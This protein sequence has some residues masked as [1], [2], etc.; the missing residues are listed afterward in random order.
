M[1]NEVADV[2]CSSFA[3]FNNR[4]IHLSLIFS[5]VSVLGSDSTLVII[6]LHSS[7]IVISTHSPL[8][9][10]IPKELREESIQLGIILMPDENREALKTVLAFLKDFAVMSNENQVLYSFQVFKVLQSV[11]R[12]F[13]L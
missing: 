7:S 12:Q 9:S 6:H 2:S 3:N 1:K 4:F 10:D 5:I 8:L 13:C 11:I